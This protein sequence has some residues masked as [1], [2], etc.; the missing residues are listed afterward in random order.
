MVTS[1]PKHIEVVDVDMVPEG[2]AP[3]V[4]ACPVETQDPELFVHDVDPLLRLN[5]LRNRCVPTGR[6]AGRSKKGNVEAVTTSDQ[7]PEPSL[8]SC[9]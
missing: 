1:L 5:F 4:I 6:L 8:S 3:T 2:I 9:H 7:D